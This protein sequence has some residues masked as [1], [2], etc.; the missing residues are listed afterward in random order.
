MWMLRRCENEPEPDEPEEAAEPSD[1]VSGDDRVAE[2]NGGR[3]DCARGGVARVRVGE[4]RA[5]GLSGA[6]VV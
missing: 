1:H 3:E 4:V 6:E 2:G 5:G